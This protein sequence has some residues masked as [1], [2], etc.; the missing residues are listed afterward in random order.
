MPSPLRRPS[1]DAELIDLVTAELG[2]DWPRLVAPVFDGRKAVL[3]DDR[4]ASAREDLVKLWLMDEGEIDAN[5]PQLSR[6][7]RGRRPRRRQAGFAGGRARLWP[8]D[9]TST[10]RCSAAPLPA[11][12]IR[13]RVA[14]ATKSPW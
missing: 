1:T 14:T 7:V 11:P 12:R 6:A 4:W 2:S 3:F 13:A 9:A 10:P 5:W 8:P